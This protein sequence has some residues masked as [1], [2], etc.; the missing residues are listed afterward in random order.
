MA[1]TMITPRDV[2]SGELTVVPPPRL[3]PSRRWRGAALQTVRQNFLPWIIVKGAL[4]ALVFAGR[5]GVWTALILDTVVSLVVIAYGW[6][7]ARR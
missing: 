3:A 7:L 5:I 2:Q 4:V 6:R 1:V